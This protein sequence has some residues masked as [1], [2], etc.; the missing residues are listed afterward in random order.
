MPG[1]PRPSRVIQRV[2]LAV[3]RRRARSGHVADAD[4]SG[5]QAVEAHG[6]PKSL[7]MRLLAEACLFLAGSLALSYLDEGPLSPAPQSR[8][9]VEVQPG[10]RGV[11]RA[12]SAQ[13]AEC[14]CPTDP[15]HEPT[16]ART[17]PDLGESGSS[18]SDLQ[19]VARAQT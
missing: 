13:S 1:K 12:Q 16:P 10:T 15:T 4:S 2:I 11:G 17:Q 3:L 8:N 6:D 18:C 5:A 14:A 9:A 7:A 19:E